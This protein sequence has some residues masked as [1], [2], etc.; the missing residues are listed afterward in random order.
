VKKRGF[1]CDGGG[2]YLQVSPAGCQRRRECA[3][4]SRSK[5]ASLT[6]ELRDTR[7]QRRH[8]ELR[9]PVR[10]IRARFPVPTWYRAGHGAQRRGWEARSHAQHREHGEHRTFPGVSPV[11]GWKPTGF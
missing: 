8:G 9:F 7:F 3:S 2:L 10:S 1:Y 6:T 4:A 11:A 5:N